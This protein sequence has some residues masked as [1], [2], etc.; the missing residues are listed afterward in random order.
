MV[1]EILLDKKVHIYDKLKLI[2]LFA[3]KYED[4]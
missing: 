4:E 1:S 2:I 3:L